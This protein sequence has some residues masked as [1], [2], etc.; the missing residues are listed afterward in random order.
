MLIGRLHTAQPTM[1]AVSARRP[2]ANSSGAGAAGGSGNSTSSSGASSRQAGRPWLSASIAL[3]MISTRSWVRVVSRPA[4][5]TDRSSTCATSG[6]ASSCRYIRRS[7]SVPTGSA[8]VQARS[9]DLGSGTPGPSAGSGVYPA[10]C[11]GSA[12]QRC[13]T[14]PSSQAA[15]ETPSGG[16]PCARQAARTAATTSGA[17]AGPTRPAA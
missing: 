4:S 5:S 12:W 7:A 3:T 9:T 10:R 1:C 8:S 6:S 15:G 16:S 17:L 13:R 11:P 14:D 2:S